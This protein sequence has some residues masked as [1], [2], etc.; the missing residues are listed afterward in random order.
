ALLALAQLDDGGVVGRALVAV[1]PGQVVRMPV[2]VVLAVGLVVLVVVAD[3]VVQREA[4]VRRDEVDARPRLATAPV[5]EV[6]RAGDPRRQ[7]AHRA[8][9]A[10]PEGPGA[11]AEPV[12]PF[13]PAGQELPHLVAAGAAVP[14]LG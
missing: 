7:G 6:R 2:P 10:L 4:V 13:G 1:V 11:V 8:V 3:E 14:R 5:E 12:V 9:V